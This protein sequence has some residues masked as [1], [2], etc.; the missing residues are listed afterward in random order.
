MADMNI[1]GVGAGAAANSVNGI[2]TQQ[3]DK[4]EQEIQVKDKEKLPSVDESEQVEVDFE[5][6][7]DKPDDVGEGRVADGMNGVPEEPDNIKEEIKTAKHIPS[8]DKNNDSDA[9]FGAKLKILGKGILNSIKNLF[10]KQPS[11]WKEFSERK[12]ELTEQK[13][14]YEQRMTEIGTETF[15][16]MK[17]G[18]VI[19]QQKPE[20]Q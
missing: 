15:E 1:L 10:S 11:K 14:A 9:S 20:Q 3:S 2:D 8:S 19:L 16:Q 13:Q 4:V 17:Q 7:D 6:S 18:D 12:Q 5:D